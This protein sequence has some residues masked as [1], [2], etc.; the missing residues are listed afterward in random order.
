M[1]NAA[2][3]FRQELEAAHARIAQLEDENTALRHS[4]VTAR[5]GVHA[6]GRQ[7]RDASCRTGSPSAKSSW[8]GIGLA[9]ASALS[10]SV[11]ALVFLTLTRAPVTRHAP[12]VAREYRGI[13]TAPRADA[14]AAIGA[15][16]ELDHP[17]RAD[18]QGDPKAPCNCAPG[19]PLCSC[20]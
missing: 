7:S 6:W 10:V 17:R 13:A 8:L 4:L 16:T 9:L 3:P 14:P 18:R 1:P 20:L 15:S 19:D 12:A 5:S 11:G 2:S